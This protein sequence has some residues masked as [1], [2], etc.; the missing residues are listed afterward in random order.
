MK[1]LGH[2]LMALVLAGAA[3]PLSPGAA[4]A[5]SEPPKEAPADQIQRIAPMTLTDQRRAPVALPDGRV[6]LVTFFYGHCPDVCPLLLYNLQDAMAAL[7]E[8]TRKKMGFAAITFDPARDTVE[9]NADHAEA[10]A[11]TADNNY[12]FTG[13]PE[14]LASMFKAF[15]FD[16][17]KDRDG[18]FQHV[19]MLAIM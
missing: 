7:P 2:L 12:V 10:Y 4:R 17:K 16:F 13:E 18:G 5:M 1:P 15:R 9:F 14:A 11:F 8:S 19:N 6:W 3:L